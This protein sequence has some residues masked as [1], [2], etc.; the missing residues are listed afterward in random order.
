ML[1][2]AGERYGMNSLGLIMVLLISAACQSLPG[3]EGPTGIR[4]P[5]GEQGQQG[6]QGPNG[7]QGQQGEQGIQGPNGEQGQQGEQGIQGAEAIILVKSDV[8]TLPTVLQKEWNDILEISIHAPR[9]GSILIMTEGEVISS[10]WDLHTSPVEIGISTNLDSADTIRMVKP[11]TS[12]FGE[13]FSFSLTYL[14]NVAG[15]ADHT[16]YLTG[17]SELG[18]G[19]RIERPRITAIYFLQDIN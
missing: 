17:R 11:S 19:H 13:S 5:Q 10:S 1:K 3:S 4:G 16:Y 6:I 12:A 14:Y 18:Q 15:P 7:E 8:E 2:F 9:D